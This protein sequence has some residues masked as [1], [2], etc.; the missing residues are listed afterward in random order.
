[1]SSYGHD[2]V[3][4]YENTSISSN[5][6]T[7]TI[8]SQSKQSLLKGE[9]CDECAGTTNPNFTIGEDAS[10]VLIQD[11]ENEQLL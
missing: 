11:D 10:H 2:D 5:L 4:A 6:P 3:C 8:S 9:K 1:M 7:N